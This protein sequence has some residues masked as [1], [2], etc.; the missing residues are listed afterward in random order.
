MSGF[1]EWLFG[2][3]AAEFGGEGTWHL[4]L[5]AD[6]GGA[7]KLALLVALAAMVYLTVR[8]YRREGDAPRRAK[9]LIACVRVLA[10]LAVFLVLFRPAAVFRVVRRLHSAVA[11]VID[12]SLSMS[13]ADR[14]EGTARQQLANAL[15]VDPQ[16]VETMAR[17]ALLRR[18][19]ERPD[20]ALARLAR[21]H[22][23]IVLR[24]STTEPGKA[25]YTRKLVDV[26]LVA[27]DGQ[28]ARAPEA[29]VE[30]LGRLTADGYETNLAAAIRD[31]LEAVQGLLV[32]DLV[33]LSDGQM[34]AEGAGTR[35]R[36]ALAYADKRGCR[37][38]AV[39]VGDPTPPRNLSVSALAAPREVRRESKVEMTATLAHRNMAGQTVTVR[40]LRGRAGQE[41]FT[42]VAEEQV[43]LREPS[44]DDA[45]DRSRGV[46]AVNFLVEPDEVGEFVYRA[47][48]EPLAEE[49]NP[50]DN[51]AEADVQVSE[52]QIKILFVS[53]DA[54]WE[55]Q[56]LRNFL[57]RAESMY[58]V[59]VWQ[60]NADKELNQLASTGMKL[61]QL[62][63]AMV[64]M[65][66]SPGG[67]PHPG[68]DVVILYDPQPTEGG[69]DG[70]FVN[71]LR[72]FVKLHNGGLCYIAGNKYSDT[73]LRSRGDYEPLAEMMPVVLAANTD[74]I[75][76]RIAREGPQPWPVSLTSYGVD[77]PITRLGKDAEETVAVWRA[78][79]KVYWAH[80]ILRAK[81]AA[82][83]LAVNPLRRAKADNKPEPLLAV[84][85]FGAGR[86]AFLA[87]DDTW[88]W[89]YLNDGYYH[90]RFWA[91]MVRYLAT[92]KARQVVITT[93]ADR[94]AAGEKIAVEVEAY[95][96]DFN[97]WPGESFE[98]VMV[99]RR[100]GEAVPHRLAAVAGREGRFAGSL[101]AERT[102]TFELTAL[103]G[104]AQAAE[105]V[106]SKQITVELPQ[107]EAAR[108]EADEVVMRTIASR[109]ENFLKLPELGRLA[110]LVPADTKLLVEEKPRELWD[111]NL[112]LLLVV[113]LLAVEWVLRKRY[114]MA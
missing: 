12:D 55:A 21:K 112:A 72:D 48:V 81:P 34:T 15:N 67:E 24:F 38:Y 46:Q 8:S 17:S 95:D 60:Q 37:R 71:L 58:R 1:L 41:G 18:A 26:E 20:G 54:G 4:R 27:D 79:P 68:Y 74:S 9:A 114:N 106:A 92:L 69:F 33:I 100:T 35:L 25:A 56:R 62:P 2:L 47:G 110:E 111:S 75:T 59:S 65:V 99:D 78:L 43:A 57:L 61:A 23:L 105:K 83:V 76:E 13:F 97:P 6:Y 3:D 91:N 88:R 70:A 107:A 93:G 96:E 53:G 14:Y 32:R 40:L 98:V 113:F 7:A 63:R 52:K 45:G 5:I 87:F 30:A 94:Y 101:P 16:A 64:E 11:V 89:I 10:L 80:P 28:V 31:S 50:D 29:L 44:E 39:L 86:V 109:P 36:S 103:R 90:A 19:L 85:R 84:Q 22:P 49:A 82:R 73:V 51:W 102:G 42:P 104:D 77:H 66:G 108:S